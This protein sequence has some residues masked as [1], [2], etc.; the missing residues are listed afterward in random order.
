MELIEQRD[1]DVV[2]VGDF[3]AAASVSERTLRTAFNEYF[4]VGPV[5]YL[6][7]R[8]LHQVKH[9][10]QVADP[11]A[12]SVSD[13]LVQHGVWEFGL[14]ASRYRRLFGEL[15]SDTLRTKTNS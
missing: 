8:Q 13:V 9:T 1:G 10:L 7:L 2:A 3:A 15:P 12:D 5:R 4:G 14:F 6:H 11:E